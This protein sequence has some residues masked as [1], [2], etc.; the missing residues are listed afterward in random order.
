[1]S[2]EVH[3]VEEADLVVI[4]L[5]GALDHEAD[6]FPGEVSRASIFRQPIVVDLSGVTAVQSMGIGMLVEGYKAAQRASLRMVFV[7]ARPQVSTV[8]VHTKLDTIF[9]ILPTVDDATVVLRS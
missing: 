8:L 9:E 3:T 7:G 4:H 2:F 6:G 1:M 5:R